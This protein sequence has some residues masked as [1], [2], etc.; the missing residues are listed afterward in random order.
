MTRLML[1]KHKFYLSSEG[2]LAVLGPYSGSSRD[3]EELLTAGQPTSAAD[4]LVEIDNH[5]EL[6]KP[7]SA[8]IKHMPSRSA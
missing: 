4:C 5:A 6:N 2:H 1:K 7:P 8:T 3:G